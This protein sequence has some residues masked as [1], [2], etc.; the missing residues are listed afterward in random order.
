MDWNLGTLVAMVVIQL[1]VLIA[2]CWWDY[3]DR[4]QKREQ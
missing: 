1:P 3:Q 2:V 4:R